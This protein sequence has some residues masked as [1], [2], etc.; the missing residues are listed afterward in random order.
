VLTP[1]QR[2]KLNRRYEQWVKDHNHPRGDK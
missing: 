2:V 1:E